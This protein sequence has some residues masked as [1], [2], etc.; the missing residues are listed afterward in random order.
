MG[1]DKQLK[2]YRAEK[3]IILTKIQKLQNE[4]NKLNVEFLKIEGKIELLTEQK[5]AQKE[6]E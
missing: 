5:T 1:N 6:A 2:E 4:L 3:E